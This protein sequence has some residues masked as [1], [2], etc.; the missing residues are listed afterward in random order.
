MT[1][2][3]AFQYWTNGTELC[4]SSIKTNVSAFVAE[5]EEYSKTNS[6]ASLF[7]GTKEE[8]KEQFPELFN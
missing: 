1:N 3:I 7:V 2:T 8:A 4:F 5:H 6:I